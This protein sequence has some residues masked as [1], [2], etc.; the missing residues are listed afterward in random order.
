[1]EWL[2][3]NWFFLVVLALCCGMHLFGHGGHGHQDAE[4]S[5]SDTE[6]NSQPESKEKS[7]GD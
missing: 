1:M 6:A 5:S 4:D 2:L 3:A 7:R